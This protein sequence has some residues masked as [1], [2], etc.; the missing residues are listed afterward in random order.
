M[1]PLPLYGAHGQDAQAAAHD[2]I[3][4]AFKT[5]AFIRV[6][7]SP[8]LWKGPFHEIIRGLGEPNLLV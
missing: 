6:E 4:H 5:A 2:I 8:K 3:C 7:I 1:N